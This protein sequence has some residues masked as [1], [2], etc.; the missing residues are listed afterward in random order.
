[1]FNDIFQHIKFTKVMTFFTA[2][3][4]KDYEEFA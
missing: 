3:T 2:R 4:S 1:M